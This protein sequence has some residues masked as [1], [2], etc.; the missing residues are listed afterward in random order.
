MH[1]L[2]TPLALAPFAVGALLPV[3]VVLGAESVCPFAAVTGVPC[4]WC[5]ATR[6]FVLAGHLDGRWLDYG[7]VWVLAFAVLALVPP[8]RRMLRLAPVLAT[9]VVAWAWALAHASTIVS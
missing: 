2:V 9:V 7:A 5:G 1:R 4:P 3:H 6:A 8:A